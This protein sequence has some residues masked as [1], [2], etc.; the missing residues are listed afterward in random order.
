MRQTVALRVIILIPT[1]EVEMLGKPF[2]DHDPSMDDDLISHI[3][4]YFANVYRNQ[5]AGD[6]SRTFH[7]AG[8]TRGK[9]D[10]SWNVFGVPLGYNH[11]ANRRQT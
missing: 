11:I 8:V 3:I 7:S 6:W 10:S 1:Y 4:F 9:P 5:D 2:S